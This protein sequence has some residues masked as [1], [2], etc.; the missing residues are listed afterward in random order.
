MNFKYAKAKGAGSDTI[1][2]PLFNFQDGEDGEHEG[3]NSSDESYFPG[4]PTKKD[5]FRKF[6]IVCRTT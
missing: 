6:A 1:F 4:F 2:A 5:V 3:K